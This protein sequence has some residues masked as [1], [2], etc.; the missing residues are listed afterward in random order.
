MQATE[1]RLVTHSVDTAAQL[2]G[3]LCGT[4]QLVGEKRKMLPSEGEKK[5]KTDLQRCRGTE[6]R[7][8][9]KEK[10]PKKTP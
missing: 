1:E 4:R 5:K 7:M 10:E 6:N 9:K 3:L 2:R 8:R